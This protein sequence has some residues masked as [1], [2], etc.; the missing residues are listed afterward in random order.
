VAGIEPCTTLLLNVSSTTEPIQRAKI[1]GPTVRTLGITLLL[2]VSSTTEPIQRRI[3]SVVE[4][5]FNTQLLNHIVFLW[6]ALVGQ[7]R[8]M[9]LCVPSHSGRCASCVFHP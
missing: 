7:G 5:T 1:A 3:G 2:N 4:L 9:W 8:E 6:V